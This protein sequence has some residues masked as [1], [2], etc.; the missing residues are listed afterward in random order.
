MNEY[1]VI[2]I[3]K[4]IICDLIFTKYDIKNNA[5]ADEM[6]NQG[7]E[8]YA[9]YHKWVL[10][11]KRNHFAAVNVFDGVYN[12]D[13]ASFF[14]LLKDNFD[15]YSDCMPDEENAENYLREKICFSALNPDTNQLVGGMVVTKQGNVQTEEFVFVHQDFRKRGIAS[16]LHAYWYEHNLNE[17]TQ[18]VAWIR[19]NNL[20][21]EQLHIKYSYVKQDTYKITMKKEY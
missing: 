19:D 1:Q 7:F 14:E 16:S 5:L 20:A 10:K 6:R 2:D 13:F 8:R 3:G 17:N 12:N 11:Q 15:P 18:F 21:S 9:T 4:T